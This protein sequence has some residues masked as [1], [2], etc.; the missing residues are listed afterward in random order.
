[1]S[2]EEESHAEFQF[3]SQNGQHTYWSWRCA[4][5][6]IYL[7]PPNA[8]ERLRDL[9]YGTWKEECDGESDRPIE[10]NSH[11]DSACRQLISCQYVDTDSDEDDDLADHEERRHVQ[12]S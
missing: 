8:D 3:P 4:L 9:L 10:G 12:A 11:E 7:N 6:C 5:C 1:M 2:W